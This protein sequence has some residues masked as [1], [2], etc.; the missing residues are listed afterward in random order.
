M[1]RPGEG[2]L[3]WRK[4]Q[5]ERHQHFL[6]G[7]Q[8]G[9][10]QIR[11][12]VDE[13]LEA[14]GDAVNSLQTFGD[15]LR[16]DGDL[17]RGLVAVSAA[18]AIEPRWASDADLVGDSV[19]SKHAGVGETLGQNLKTAPVIGMRMRENDLIDGLAER[20]HVR[21]NFVGIRQQELTIED[22]DRIW[23][24]DHLRVDLK[25]VGRAEGGMN[26]DGSELAYEDGPQA[27]WRRCILG[28]GRATV[29]R[30]FRVRGACSRQSQADEWE[31]RARSELEKP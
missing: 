11:F 29:L 20:L 26:F 9:E 4:H 25:A 21:R 17:R 10:L 8:S 7:Q 23:P 19:K 15:C 31:Q 30:Q 3:V 6:L 5:I 2:V 12:G 14:I 18:E 27:A 1:I 24:L 13:P 16:R 28:P 22:H